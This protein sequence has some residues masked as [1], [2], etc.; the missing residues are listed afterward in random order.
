MSKTK[1]RL[2]PKKHLKK[3]KKKKVNPEISL[4]PD[5]YGLFAPVPY[6]IKENT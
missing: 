3:S 1:P 5:E 6:K 2:K 4:G